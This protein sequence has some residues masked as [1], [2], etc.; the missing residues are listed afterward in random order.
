MGSRMGSLFRFKGVSVG[1]G[2]AAIGCARDISYWTVHKKTK[3][4]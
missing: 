4:E 2:M 3:K 1:S